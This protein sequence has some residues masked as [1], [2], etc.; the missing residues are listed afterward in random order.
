LGGVNS[1]AYPT[2]P[3][4]WVDP[5]GLHLTGVR[6]IGHDSIVT[7]TATDQSTQKLIDTDSG[8][9]RKVI[10]GIPDGSISKIEF[11]GHGDNQMM[12]LGGDE[13]LLKYFSEQDN[14]V[15]VT[16]GMEG[17]IETILG[18]KLAE[19][20]E[21]VLF[22]CNTANGDNNITREISKKIPG[23][24]VTGGATFQFSPG[25]FI[26]SLSDLKVPISYS[27]K[28]GERQPSPPLPEQLDHNW[29]PANYGTKNP[30]SK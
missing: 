24:T 18:P 17:D 28:D 14:K 3:V 25:L 21:V 29:V 2:N 20:A 10:N 9:L 1:F 22:G 11:M 19:N 6:R 15:H 30:G 4:G 7:I 16:L 5:L 8:T 26:P 23:A 27:Y 13:M 12:G